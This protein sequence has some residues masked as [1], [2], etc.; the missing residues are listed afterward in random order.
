MI[1]V[2]IQLLFSLSLT[3]F[4]YY[5]NKMNRKYI[6]FINLCQY[7]RVPTFELRA[8]RTELNSVV[9]ERLPHYYF[10]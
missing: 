6:L 8:A 1:T 10:I 7:I 9:F 4:Y 5:K 2:M 3:L